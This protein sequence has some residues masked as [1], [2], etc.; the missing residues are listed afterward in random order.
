MIDD[1]EMYRLGN[2]YK[3]VNNFA[4]ME[5]YYLLAAEN[6][7]HSAMNNL[8]FYYEKIKNYPEMKKYYMM[9]IAQNNGHAMYNLG[10]YYEQIFE[11]YNDEDIE[12]LYTNEPYNN[13]EFYPSIDA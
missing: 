1:V 7:N 6:N 12:C 13:Y 8:G 9:S 5:K 2:Y 3:S 10:N 11:Q 4:E